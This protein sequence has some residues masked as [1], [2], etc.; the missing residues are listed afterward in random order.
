[1]FGSLLSP[2]WFLV[3]GSGA[4]GVTPPVEKFRKAGKKK[5]STCCSDKLFFPQTAATSAVTSAR[6]A[7]AAATPTTTVV[8]AAAASQCHFQRVFFF[9]P[10]LPFTGKPHQNSF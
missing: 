10:L 9:L 6:A 5:P 3:S 4:A 7:A 2:S 1:M 8:D